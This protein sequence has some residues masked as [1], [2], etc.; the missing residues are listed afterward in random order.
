MGAWIEIALTLVPLLAIKVAPHMGAW[1]EIQYFHFALFDGQVAPHMG[2]W[3][4]MTSRY[5]L[6]VG[7]RSHPT[8]VRGLKCF[9][10]VRYYASCMS[11][12]TWVRGLKSSSA[13]RFLLTIECRTPHGCVD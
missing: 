9:G 13:L 4:E 5:H 6:N 7:L 11:H 2:A 8:W 12:P 1:I 3:I 10:C